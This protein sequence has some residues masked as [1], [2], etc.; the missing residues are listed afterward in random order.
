MEAAGQTRADAFLSRLQVRYPPGHTE[1]FG[2][3]GA[4]NGLALVDPRSWTLGPAMECMHVRISD[5]VLT[6]PAVVATISF[7]FFFSP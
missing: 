2:S 4:V 3:T 1:G 5:S 6:R 7:F